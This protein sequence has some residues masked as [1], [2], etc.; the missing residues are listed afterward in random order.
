M[1][2][3]GNIARGL[4]CTTMFFV[5]PM[6][7]FVC[8]HVLVVLFFRGRRAHEGDDAS[9]LNRKDRRVAITLIV[10]FSSL[11]PALMVDNV[12]SV[13]ALTGTVGASCLAYIGPGLIYMAVYGEEFLQKVDEIWG[14]SNESEQQPQDVESSRLLETSKLA[15]EGTTE[16]NTSPK[17]SKG[18]AWYV[19][20]MPI[21]CFIAEMGKKKLAEFQEQEALKSP[22]I[23]RLGNVSN[24]PHLEMQ[25]VPIQQ[26]PRGGS[27]SGGDESLLMPSTSQSS[28]GPKM[29]P[30]GSFSGGNQAIGA[31][32]LAKKQSDGNLAKRK[33]KGGEDDGDE[34]DIDDPPTWFDFCYAIFFIAFGIVALCAGLVAILMSD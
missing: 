10:Y 2:R 29:L 1:K 13:L 16:S 27:F 7:S 32:I 11:I 3:A 28:L 34:A 14:T 24:V 33:F 19:L 5:Y 9:V 18:I 21:W 25:K 20:L 17:L 8:R 22:H 23:N 12:G 26:R 30:Y 31:A 6:D 4:M 15:T